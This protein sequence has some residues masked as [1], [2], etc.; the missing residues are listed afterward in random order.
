MNFVVKIYIYIAIP[1]DAFKRSYQ[2]L[3]CSVDIHTL[4]VHSN[5]YIFNSRKE[6]PTFYSIYLSFPLTQKL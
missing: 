6:R 2:R 3:T 1:I 4:L 5:S